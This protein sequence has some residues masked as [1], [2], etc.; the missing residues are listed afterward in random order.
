MAGICKRYG[1]Q[2]VLNGVDFSVEAGSAAAIIGKNGCGKSTLLSIMAGLL[3]PDRGQV[4]LEGADLLT[5]RA[6]RAKVGYVA[7]GDCLFEELTVA[8]NLAFWASAS[9]VPAK[10]L[11]GNYYVRLL[12]LDAF[13]GKR[14]SRLSGGMR[15]RT[16]ICTA[17]LGDPAHL[18]LDEPF[19]GLDLL[20]RQELAAFMGQLR[21]MG[22]TLVYTTHSPEEL[23]TL[24]DITLL[25]AEGKILLRQP[26]AELLKGSDIQTTLITLLKGEEA[27]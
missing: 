4:L 2:P 8:D 26:T 3:V 11:N 15:R 6:L 14:V 17:L 20:Y 7:Q 5:N 13:W 22:K 1:A 18:L 10:G 23:A 24:S 25:L 27:R 19:T 16:A 12:G 9:G 21:Q